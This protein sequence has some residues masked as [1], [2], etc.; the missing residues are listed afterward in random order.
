[1]EDKRKIIIT[2]YA[3]YD[4]DT[5]EDYLF[6]IH[7]KEDIELLPYIEK[8]M[9][10]YDYTKD[11]FFQSFQIKVDEEYEITTGSHRFTPIEI[12]YGTILNNFYEKSHFFYNKKLANY[13]LSAVEK[14]RL[15]S[16]EL[17]GYKTPNRYMNI[18][19]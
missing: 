2:S 19:K 15:R 16:I 10:K 6:L 11:G 14:I 17:S 4:G 9:L 5:M 7:Y 18:R 1:M 8:Y 3:L 12:Y 13:D